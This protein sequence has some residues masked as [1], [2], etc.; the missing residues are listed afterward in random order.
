LLQPGE[1]FLV[2]SDDDL[3]TQFIGNTLLL[4]KAEQFDFSRDAGFCLE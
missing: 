3:A 2:G 1:L 4:T